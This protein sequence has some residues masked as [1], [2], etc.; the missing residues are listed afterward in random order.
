MHTVTDVETDQ[1][2]Q[3]HWAIHM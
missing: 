3:L 1:A 2:V